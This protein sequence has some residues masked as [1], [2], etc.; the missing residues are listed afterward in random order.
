ME[1]KELEIWQQ[2]NWDKDLWHGDN[3]IIVNTAALKDREEFADVFISY[4][5]EIFAA[6][7]QYY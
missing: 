7:Q 4:A 2:D 6:N 1:Y 3:G 5:E